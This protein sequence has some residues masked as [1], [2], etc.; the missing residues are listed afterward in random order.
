METDVINQEEVDEFDNTVLWSIQEEVRATKSRE[1]G[2]ISGFYL[3]I[4]AVL[5][6]L[7]CVFVLY[8]ANRKRKMGALE[9]MQDP[10][11][12]FEEFTDQEE[13]NDEKEDNVPLI[14]ISE[15]EE[16]IKSPVAPDTTTSQPPSSLSSQII[17]P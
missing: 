15:D 12:V 9:M 1:Q 14:E 3:I 11:N 6:F 17:Q 10:N 13:N 5:I 4:A 8:F 2:Y 7:I 16:T